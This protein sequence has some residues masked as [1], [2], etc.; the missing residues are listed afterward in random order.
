MSDKGIMI[1]FSKETI[2]TLYNRGLSSEIIGSGLFVLF[3]L[4]EQRYDLLDLFDDENTQRR[5]IILYRTLVRKNLLEDTWKDAKYHYQLTKLGIE[6][7]EYIKSIESDISTETFEPVMVEETIQDWIEEYRR[8]FPA[9]NRDH[10][11]NL[12]HRME[13]F[14]RFFKYDKDVILAASRAYNK[15]QDRLETEPNFRKRSNTFIYTHNLAKESQLASWCEKILEKK[16]SNEM[17]TSFL[18]LA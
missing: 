17:D 4:Y 9:S 3:A 8:T 14:I 18:N 15:E 13:E 6:I 7:V 12:L 16:D 10:V 11:A 2:E 5:A 1:N